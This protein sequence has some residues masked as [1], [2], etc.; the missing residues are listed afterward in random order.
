[1]VDGG[2]V[3]AIAWITGLVAGISGAQMKARRIHVHVL[4][5]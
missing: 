3:G 2:G 5:H 1:M 4:A